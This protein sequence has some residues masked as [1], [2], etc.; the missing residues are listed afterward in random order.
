LRPAVSAGLST[1]SLHLEL[2]DAVPLVPDQ[3]S[4]ALSP[5]GSRFVYRSGKPGATQL[6][7]RTLD[8]E[9]V[10]PIP[11]TENAHSPFF[12]PD[13]QHL[14]FISGTTIQHVLLT[15]GRPLEMCGVLSLTPGSPG[16]TWGE[17]GMVVFAAGLGG[18]FAVP[19][20][21][22][23]VER[24]TTPNLERGE[25]LHYGPQFLRGAKELLFM[26]RLKG[27]ATRV[28]ILSLETRQWREVEGMTDV[29][30]TVGYASA[31]NRAYVVYAQRPIGSSISQLRAVEL[32]VARAA[33]KGGALP[34]GTVWVQ[35]GGT[36]SVAHFSVSAN[37]ML[38]YIAA[39]ASGALV[40][41]SRGDRKAMPLTAES[42][43]Y[44]YPR[45]SPGA[46]KVAV[47]LED[48]GSQVAVVDRGNVR[49]LTTVGTNTHPTW[50]T[51]GSVAI[52]AMQEGRDGYDVYAVRYDGNAIA[53]PQ[54]IFARP[55]NQFPSGYSRLRNL[56]AFYELGDGGRDIFV[57]SPK[58]GAAKVVATPR[59]ERLATFSRDGRFIAYVSDQLDG[60]D[61]VW[62]QKYPLDDGSGPIQISTGGGTEPIWS[63]SDDELF[64]RRRTELMSVRMGPNGRPLQPPVKELDEPYELARPEV[65]RPNYDVFPDGRSFVM[66]QAGEVHRRVPFIVNWFSEL[67]RQS[68]GR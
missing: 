40:R 37:G 4:F 55:G 21:G 31:N 46:S 33:V 8:N 50:M 12:S 61:E 54:R 11:G 63:P 24:L 2:P 43:A 68:T 66:V 48:V 32:D 65:G 47:V 16:V 39:H 64:F 42:H 59:N 26:I 29:V 1:A 34:V 49:Q 14:G 6:F 19:A 67:Q 60:R 18:L 51:D 20:S 56:L 30:G 62:V 22:G 5:D 10:Q 13:S 28:A 57:W 3:L 35:T 36:V 25:E 23:N 45:V 38:A 53:E 17:N 41:V 7:V 9:A 52:A 44:R 58:E 15:G 27:G